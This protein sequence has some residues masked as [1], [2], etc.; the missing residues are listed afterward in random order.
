MS[1]NIRSSNNIPALL[2]NWQKI[3]DAI[4]NVFAEY[5][6]NNHIKLGYKI[7]AD[8]IYNCLVELVRITLYSGRIARYIIYPLRHSTYDPDRLY[9]MFHFGIS[10][11][12]NR[13]DQLEQGMFQNEEG[14]NR[15][16][17][18][19]PDDQSSKLLIKVLDDSEF[20][21][22]KYQ[23][24][25]NGIDGV[26]GIGNLL[27]ELPNVRN[28]FKI[29][30]E[31]K[32]IGDNTR[33]FILQMYGYISQLRDTIVYILDDSIIRTINSNGGVNNVTITDVPAELINIPESK[34]DQHMVF[35]HNYS[36]LT[37]DAI[38]NFGINETNF[39]YNYDYSDYEKHIHNDPGTDHTAAVN[40]CFGTDG[41]LSNYLQ[42]STYTEH[43][44][45]SDPNALFY[46]K[47]RCKYEN[48]IIVSDDTKV[49]PNYRNGSWIRTQDPNRSNGANNKGIVGLLLGLDD[50]VRD[51]A[52]R[53][54]GFFTNLF[55][56]PGPINCKYR[57]R[58]YFNNSG[59][60][61]YYDDE[62]YPMF[63]L[64]HL[65]NFFDIWQRTEYGQSQS[66]YNGVNYY[67]S[68]HGPNTYDQDFNQRVNNTIICATQSA[69]AN[70]PSYSNGVYT[71]RLYP[72][73]AVQ[74]RYYAGPNTSAQCVI[75]Y[76]NLTT[77]T[78]SVLTKSKSKIGSTSV[79]YTFP[80]DKTFTWDFTQYGQHFSGS[81]T[82]P[83]K[84]DTGT[85]IECS[86]NNRS[87]ITIPKNYRKNYMISNK[88]YFLTRFYIDGFTQN[89]GT[90]TTT[91]TTYSLDASIDANTAARLAGCRAYGNGLILTSHSSDI[92]T[93]M[94][95]W[96]SQG[97][98]FSY[99]YTAVI[100][101][102]DGKQYKYKVTAYPTFSVKEE[103][104]GH[105]RSFFHYVTWKGGG[106]ININLGEDDHGGVKSVSGGKAKVNKHTSTTT[107]TVTKTFNTVYY[108][109]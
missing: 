19:I 109:Y 54:T 33:N 94:N 25:D 9:G 60:N 14:Y 12:Y 78:Y 80:S 8:D 92:S 87:V 27:N 83:Y 34:I 66:D 48:K 73:F 71:L 3:Y 90:V 15:I 46:V 39:L 11:R 4:N 37:K 61:I 18:A 5:F 101:L 10:Y 69:V 35:F 52:N 86:G 82:K 95:H 36:I 40:A 107:K 84:L 72:V 89:V 68:I 21:D 49:N 23:I 97:H 55:G 31:T 26:G 53:F 79:T 45:S 108:P 64:Y 99:S 41:C 1:S 42:L 17:H 43:Y 63:S 65:K 98:A 58:Y 2:P 105:G 104:P 44:R 75:D 93:G 13:H 38:G 32:I 29:I 28:Q 77:S 96:R 7:T 56:D 100:T 88:P 6:A 70:N 50:V 106:H 24:I 102:R 81:V 91:I 16:N 62:F 22:E 20:I 47:D 85:W 57:I 30:R 74:V 103:Y 59:G 51:I 76:Y 67:W